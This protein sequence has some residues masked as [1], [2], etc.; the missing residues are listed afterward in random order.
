[1]TMWKMNSSKHTKNFVSRSDAN[2]EL[3][4]RQVNVQ[5]HCE[6]IETLNKVVMIE[7]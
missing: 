5:E 1:M 4:A 3:L 2:S 6:K 7:I